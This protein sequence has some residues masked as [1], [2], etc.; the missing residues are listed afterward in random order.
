MA[1]PYGRS[2]CMS[3][4]LRRLVVVDV[5]LSRSS[6]NPILMTVKLMSYDR[7]FV[8]FHFKHSVN[9]VDAGLHF[10]NLLVYCF[11]ATVNNIEPLIHV[12]HE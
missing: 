6:L 10:V 5:E 7:A 1:A 3:S 12:L 4:S 11:E 9:F 8:T 2:S